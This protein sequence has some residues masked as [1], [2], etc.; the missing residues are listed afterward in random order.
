MSPYFYIVFFIFSTVI[1]QSLHFRWVSL[2]SF[3][4]NYPLLD[5]TYLIPYY[6]YFYKSP[7]QLSIIW[8]RIYKFA[9]YERIIWI[10]SIF[11]LF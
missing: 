8:R 11:I 10:L 2:C 4:I 5:F 1:T 3:D 6:L 7:M 9:M